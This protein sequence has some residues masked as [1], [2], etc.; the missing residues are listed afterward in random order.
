MSK[1]YT[2]SE[3]SAILG[4]D[5]ETLKKKCQAHQIPGAIK[6]D[7]LWLL[8]EFAVLGKNKPSVGVYID[9]SNI[10]HGGKN[11]GWQV[12]YLFLKQFI[13]NKYNI[14]TISYY[15]S[16][17][18]KQ[19]KD[20]KYIKDAKGNYVLDD[21][22]LGFENGLR[23]IGFRIFTKPLKFIN[24]DEKNPS[25]K[26][27]GDLMIDAMTEEKQW[28]ELILLAGDCDFERLVKKISSIPKR[29][30]IFSFNSR[31]SH[32]L[33]E[34]AL[35]SPYVTFTP[36]EDLRSILEYKKGTK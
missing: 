12:G 3:A 11:V 31:M 9:G 4:I 32:E 6:K 35:N 14:V 26:T 10:Y 15:N 20:K 23:G 2:L 19:D 34:L 30:S 33:R 28:D 24:K 7:K 21:K 5:Q 27:D 29:V 18:Y 13:E 17:G 8:P 1:V 25:N 16:T 36:L 22:A